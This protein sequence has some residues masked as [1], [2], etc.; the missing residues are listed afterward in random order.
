MASLEQIFW[1][2][3]I[4]VM[5]A[6]AYTFYTKKI[7]GG[8][9]RALLNENAFSESRAV[10]FEDIGYKPGFFLKYAL[11]DGSAFS[12]TVKSKNGKYYIPEDKI[13][14]AESKY[15]GESITVLIMLVAILAFAAVALLCIYLFP[16][17]VE[18]AEG[19]FESNQ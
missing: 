15:K 8:F 14:K 5:I 9:V 7:L 12:E 17:L 13:E 18:M 16:E 11:R 19:L 4:G 3:I 10:S 6:A 2:F 1:A